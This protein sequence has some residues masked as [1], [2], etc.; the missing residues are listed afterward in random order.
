MAM[1]SCAPQLGVV[2]GARA[3]GR[4][5]G[6]PKVSNLYINQTLCCFGHTCYA[7]LHGATEP[8]QSESPVAIYLLRSTMAARG[9]EM[10][11]SASN[12]EHVDSGHCFLRQNINAAVAEANSGPASESLPPAPV[13]AVDISCFVAREQ[14]SEIHRAKVVSQVLA[15]SESLGF[16]NIVGHGVPEPIIKSTLS[17]LT[18]FFE[19]PLERKKQCIATSSH[20]TQRGY[21]PFKMENHNAV[22]GR[23]GPADLRETFS[24]GPPYH[25]GGEEYGANSYPDF[26]E[27]FQQ[28][29]EDY[30]SEMERL[31][32]VMLEIFTLALMQATNQNLHP[33]YLLE[34]IKP[35][36]GLMKAC[37]YPAFEGLLAD[38]T[39]V[40]G[41]TDWGPLTILL[42]TAPGLE[43]C[44]KS[45]KDHVHQWRA[46]PVFPGAFTINVADQLARWS[47]DRFVSCIHRVNADLCSQLSRISI[48]YFSTQ[49]LPRLSTAEPKV[50]CIC[51]DGEDPKYEPLS[52]RDYL[53]RNFSRLKSLVKNGGA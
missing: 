11:S 30:Y 5:Q 44:I 4:T 32:T 34:Q 42:T 19:C 14:F 43:V 47:N 20:G 23:P 15:A 13:P 39:R 36:R 49:V 7:N 51:A 2:V 31:E 6:A 21:T 29:I 38:E 33:N 10:T 16:M 27:K 24:F 52:V 37:W 18:S 3:T 35:N 46:V 8:R 9:C 1:M 25:A 48:P 50:G 17:V 45:Q 12:S 41:H 22:L 28:H 53:E 40:S 26:V